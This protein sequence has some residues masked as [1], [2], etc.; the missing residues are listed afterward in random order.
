M[1]GSE[2][3]MAIVPL[4]ARATH[5]SARLGRMV[6]GALVLAGVALVTATVLVHREPEAAP[7]RTSIARTEA[8][9]ASVVT[10]PANA[11]EDTG[12]GFTE[13]ELARLPESRR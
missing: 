5:V 1:A 2:L 12:S 8:H 9:T 13:S 3:A 11:S 7:F 4:H 10:R 6:A